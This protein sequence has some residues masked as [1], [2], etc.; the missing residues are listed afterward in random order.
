MCINGKWNCDSTVV[1]YESRFI[2]V[3]AVTND[4]LIIDRFYSV[5]ALK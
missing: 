3:S 2:Q 4:L 1:I 5:A